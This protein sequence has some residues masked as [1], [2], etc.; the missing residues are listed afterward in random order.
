M[1]SALTITCAPERRTPLS[2]TEAKSVSTAFS[3]QRATGSVP[4]SSSVAGTTELYTHW[5]QFLPQSFKAMKRKLPA[6]LRR[7]VVDIKG[8]VRGFAQI[9]RHRQ[10]VLS[11]GDGEKDQRVAKV[12][13]STLVV[14]D[15]P[16]AARGLLP[17][18]RNDPVI[19]TTVAKLSDARQRVSSGKCLRQFFFNWERTSTSASGSPLRI[20]LSLRRTMAGGR[21]RSIT[22]DDDV[23]PHREPEG[24]PAENFG[25]SAENSL[26]QQ[27][28]EQMSRHSGAKTSNGVRQNGVARHFF[29]VKSVHHGDMR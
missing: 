28:P 18:H 10:T 12:H 25:A 1:P 7:K 5:F 19:P 23:F 13:N 6:F 27:R 14:G 22:A 8:A 21:G 4:I 17:A 11:P 20:S 16:S 29:H 24:P 26:G 9:F 2:Q 15:F 3:M